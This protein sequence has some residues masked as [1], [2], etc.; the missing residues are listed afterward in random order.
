MFYDYLL[1]MT[2]I[3]NIILYLLL[4][5]FFSV[6]KV[7]T[8]EKTTICVVLSHDLKSYQLVYKNILY[9]LA[10]HH[11]VVLGDTPVFVL[12]KK[13]DTKRTINSIKKKS[14]HIILTIGTEA[15]ITASEFIHDTPIIFTMVYQNDVFERRIKEKNNIRGVFLNIDETELFRT[16]KNMFPHIKNVGMLYSI[17]YFDKSVLRI[18]RAA[19]KSGFALKKRNIETADVLPEALNELMAS[20]EAFFLLPDPLLMNNKT[21]KIIMSKTLAN[22]ILVFGETFQFVEMNGL[23]G[24]I[25]NAKKIVQDTMTKIK[26]VLQDNF[27]DVQ[28]TKCTAF[29]LVINERIAKKLGISF[30][31][32]VLQKA[33]IYSPKHKAP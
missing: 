29:H 11:D 3:R 5:C 23:L 13:V 7:Y 17:Q 26:N 30:T 4:C 18:E 14:P 22:N 27:S 31:P 10:N 28:N 21:I 20:I 1:N 2:K 12:N 16:L 32:D 15:T 9:S 6:S 8:Q 19:K 25:F 24:F 33:K